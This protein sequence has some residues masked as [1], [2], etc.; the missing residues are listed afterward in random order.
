M[1]R[2][3]RSRRPRTNRRMPRSRHRPRLVCAAR[4][5]VPLAEG[6]RGLR[7][8]RWADSLYQVAQWYP[9]VAVYDDLRGWDTEPYLGASEFYNNYGS[10]DVRIDVPAGWIVGATGVLQNG[11]AVLTPAARTR[12]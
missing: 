6:E 10:F 4:F 12:L 2:R 8:G 5:R 1:V 3:S 11:D 9:R 7:M